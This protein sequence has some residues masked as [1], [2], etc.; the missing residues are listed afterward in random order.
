MVLR[1]RRK[2][3]VVADPSGGGSAV[4]DWEERS[5]AALGL[6]E[7]ARLSQAVTEEIGCTRLGR[8][9]LGGSKLRRRDIGDSWLGRTEGSRELS[10]EM[11]G[12]RQLRDGMKKIR[13]LQAWTEKALDDSKL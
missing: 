1:L 11:D 2:E 12:V 5:W 13:R 10:A 9:K 3:L 7:G 6:K 4:P 8:R